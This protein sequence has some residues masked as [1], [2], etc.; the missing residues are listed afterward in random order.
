MAAAKSD[1]DCLKAP[2]DATACVDNAAD[3]HTQKAEAKVLSRF[4]EACS[5]LPD[6]GVSGAKCCVGGETP[7]V[8]CEDDATCVSGECRAG[9]CLATIAEVEANA[10]AHDLFGAAVTAPASSKDKACVVAVARAA[11]AAWAARWSSFLECT[12]DSFAS[13]DGDAALTRSCLAPQPDR[14][15]RIAKAESRVTVLTRKKCVEV[16]DIGPLGLLFAGDCAAAGPGGLAACANRVARC[17]FCR[18]VN[19]ADAIEPALSC[20]AFDDGTP[21]GTC[22]EGP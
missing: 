1:V 20:D 3:E 12:V 6:W 11:G 15:G 10:L 8:T 14:N 4:E 17:R 22:P 2:G 7:G 19:V 21:N 18:W 5:V 9:G 13:I 16:A